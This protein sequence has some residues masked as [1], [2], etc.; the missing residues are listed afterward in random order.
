ME[1]A[2]SAPSPGAREDG[3]APYLPAVL[4]LGCVCATAVLWR[5]LRGGGPADKLAQKVDA[6][7]NMLEEITERERERRRGLE[8]EVERMRELKRQK[9]EDIE[10]F[11][12][13]KEE[14]ELKVR[15]RQLQAQQEASRRKESQ[16]EQEERE[17]EAVRRAH[18]EGM[19]C[20]LRDAKGTQSDFTVRVP[21]V[22][23]V[24]Y[25]TTVSHLKSRIR[26]ECI[27]QPPEERQRIIHAGKPQSDAVKLID[28]LNAHTPKTEPVVFFLVVSQKVTA[29]PA[30]P[31][32]AP[33]AAQ[34]APIAPLP[35]P[36]A[37]P[38]P[39]FPH[40]RHVRHLLLACTC[41][42]CCCA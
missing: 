15:Q 24:G 12:R 29:P 5:A 17:K 31:P 16:L 35:D 38:F 20:V 8:A 37:V 23:S 11:R 7:K 2:L 9:A 14:E 21:L 28:L 3:D 22:D 34:S 26:A 41:Q 32:P 4:A 39:H 25:P 36:E 18:R 40:V 42:C 19:D 13:I 1:G 30:R 10:R 33:A 27:G 6:T